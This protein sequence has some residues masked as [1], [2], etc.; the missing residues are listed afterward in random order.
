M[1]SK[2]LTVSTLSQQTVHSPLTSI[3]RAFLRRGMLGA[4]RPAPF[5]CSSC[6][7]IAGL[8]ASLAPATHNPLR[9][10]NAPAP[11][12]PPHRPKTRLYAPKMILTPPVD[13]APEPELQVPW[14]PVTLLAALRSICALAAVA[15][16][17]A[18]RRV[19]LIVV[20]VVAG[21]V[22]WEVLLYRCIVL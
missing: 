3:R 16:T 2:Q 14:R 5:S 9:V 11:P 7:F 13:T 15:S 12:I 6:L 10:F 4:P 8:D 18:A 17:A 21:G 1:S 22:W 20:L 19:N